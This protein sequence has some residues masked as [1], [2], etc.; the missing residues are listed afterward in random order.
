MN[1]NKNH[2]E[3]QNIVNKIVMLVVTVQINQKNIKK[4]K[5]KV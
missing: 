3:N 1:P 5:T 2:K 4:R